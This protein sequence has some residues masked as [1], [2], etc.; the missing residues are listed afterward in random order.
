MPNWMKIGWEMDKDESEEK[1]IKKEKKINVDIDDD[2]NAIFVSDA[3]T[4]CWTMWVCDFLS[5]I[6]PS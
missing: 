4:I 1:K 6:C 3:R 5:N 2:N